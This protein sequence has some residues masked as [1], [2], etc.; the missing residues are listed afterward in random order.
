MSLP[1]REVPEGLSAEEYFKLGKEYKTIGWTE[2]A[3]DALQFAV[4]QG[5]E[6]TTGIAAARFL[7]TKIPRFPVPLYAEQ[8]N[9]AGFNQMNSGE[10]KA[11]KKTFEELIAEFPD[12][13]WPYGNLSHLLLQEGKTADAIRLLNKALEINT[14]YVNGWLRMATARTLELDFKSARSCVERAL[15]ADP[16]EVAAL[17]MKDA[18]EK[19]RDM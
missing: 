8:K 5:G 3:R 10:L 18:L 12:F 9:I 6:S 2:Q 16:H 19:M 7:R 17:A 11:A 4:E 1:P 15:E 13:E 14:Y